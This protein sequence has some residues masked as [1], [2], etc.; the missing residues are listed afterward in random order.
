MSLGRSH[1]PTQ[2]AMSAAA[3]VPVTAINTDIRS[4]HP[5]LG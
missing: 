2:K 5:A 4:S 3:A 1:T